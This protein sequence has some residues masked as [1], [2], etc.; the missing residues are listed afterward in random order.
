MVW[1]LYPA[2]GQLNL[3]YRALI[4]IHEPFLHIRVKRVYSAFI[5]IMQVYHDVLVPL[6]L[7]FLLLEVYFKAKCAIY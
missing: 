4:L 3:V 1:K 2:Y 6:H 5:E 7:T